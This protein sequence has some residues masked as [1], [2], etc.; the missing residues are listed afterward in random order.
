MHALATTPGFSN[1]NKRTAW[2][3]TDTFLRANGQH[4]RSIP[5]IA[6]EAIVNAVVESL[7]FREDKATEWLYEHRLRAS[8]RHD[9]SLV[10]ESV[11]VN[12]TG[13]YTATKVMG[14]SMEM[15]TRPHFFAPTIL[16]RL[17]GLGADGG[18][19]AVITMDIE[20]ASRARVALIADSEGET[21]AR[22]AY[23]EGKLEAL[24]SPEFSAELMFAKTMPSAY[25]PSG[26]RP[27][28]MVWPVPLLVFEPGPVGI[29]LRLDG[30]LMHRIE[31]SF[32]EYPT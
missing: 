23:K 7:D 9:Y 12:E 29:E 22:T 4:L 19:Q 6:G 25:I 30:E 26:V 32:V 5:A 28:V 11:L 21:L 20:H 18:R 31:L 16:T 14:S 3:A 27:A 2:I 13:T 17:F 15:E 1:G 24:A 10:A 8:D